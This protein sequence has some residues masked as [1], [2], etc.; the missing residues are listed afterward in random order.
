MINKGG[1][2]LHSVAARDLL[3]AMPA[4]RALDH[5]V[6]LF[7]LFQALFSVLFPAHALVLIAAFVAVPLDVALAAPNVLTDVAHE[8]WAVIL[9]KHMPGA[10]SKLALV[11]LEVICCAVAA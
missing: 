1:D 7:V 11:L 10:F 2:S 6:V 9:C 3:D 4:G 5:A 8:C